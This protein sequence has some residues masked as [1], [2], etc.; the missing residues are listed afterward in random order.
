[1]ITVNI[2]ISVVFYWVSLSCL[3]RC[4]IHCFCFKVCNWASVPNLPDSEAA[5]KP[6]PAGWSGRFRTTVSHSPCSTHV[7]VWAIPGELPVNFGFVHILYF[8]IVLRL[9]NCSLQSVA[10]QEVMCTYILYG[11]SNFVLCGCKWVRFS[12]HIEISTIP[13]FGVSKWKASFTPSL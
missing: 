8:S 12:L 3:K 7:W 1:V 9:K 2:N 5:S 11:L 4:R 10:Q 13:C 6:W